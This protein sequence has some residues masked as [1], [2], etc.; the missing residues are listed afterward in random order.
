MDGFGSTH[1][2]IDHLGYD[3]DQSHKAER[4]LPLL[5]KQLQ[6][7]PDRIYLWWHLGSVYRDLGRLAEA[8]AAWLRGADV[9]GT[10]RAAGRSSALCL[11]ELAKLRLLNGEEAMGPCL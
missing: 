9:A 10:V 5:R 6:A 7:D 11:I 3:G 4:N 1:L 2:I 8:A